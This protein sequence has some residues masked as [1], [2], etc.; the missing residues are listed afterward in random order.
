LH[1]PPFRKYHRNSP[2]LTIH[3]HPYFEYAGYLQERILVI[4]PI[5]LWPSV[6]GI[7]FLILGFIFFRRDIAAASGLDK[8]VVLGPVFVAAPLA[9]F[10]AEHQVEGRLMAGMV[11]HW[12]PWHVF[13]IYFVGLALIAAALSLT[14]RRCLLWSAS[15]L[16]ILFLIFVLTMDLPA[17]IAQPT[18]RINWV[19]LLRE[20]SFGSG[21]LALTGILLRQKSDQ[22]SKILI[23]LAR[24][25]I[26]VTLLLYGVQHFL[27]PECV[28]GV[29][30][31][32]LIPAWVPIPR[33]WADLTGAILLVAG[34]AL[35]INKRSRFAATLVGLVMVVITVFLYTP[36]WVM[37]RGPEQVIEGINYV[38]D[39]LLYGGTVLLL[40]AALSNV[41]E[42]PTLT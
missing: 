16:A 32:K 37:D 26:G 10:G 6:A 12:I 3:I 41:R 9:T 8:L 38:F 35:L 11:P 5:E 20:T 4:A 21:A 40:A 39:T 31:E 25:L 27:H 13:W 18:N 19:L 2:S 28:T 30:L 15:L 34:I 17:T 7:V 22:L 1:L 14:F 23:F 33:F 36:I 42:K 24:I 29:P